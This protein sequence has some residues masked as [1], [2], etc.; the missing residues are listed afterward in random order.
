MKVDVTTATNSCQSVYPSRQGFGETRLALLLTCNVVVTLLNIIVNIFLIFA[1][2][3]T[4]QLRNLSCKLIACLSL[5]DICVGLVLQNV[6]SVLLTAF[7]SENGN[8][9]VE[10]V[11]QFLSYTFPQI[12]GVMIMIIALDR[13]VHMKFL[14][15]YS[16]MMNQRTACFMI[17]GNVVFALG[18]AIVSVVA[19]VYKKFFLF[20]AVL[21]I[22]DSIVI[23]LI[24]V[25]YIFT[26]RSVRAHMKGMR[27]RAKE[28]DRVEDYHRAQSTT[29]ALATTAAAAGAISKK[30][31]KR[32][33]QLAKTMV[34]ILTSL[35]VCYI[36][37][38]VVG[39]YW[40]YV[41][42]Y[43]NTMTSLALDTLVWVSFLL[44]YMNSSLNAIIFILRNK[45]MRRLLKGLLG[46]QS[47]TELSTIESSGPIQS[48]RV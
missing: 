26:F 5:S 1:L 33:A 40:S 17:L 24:Y 37:Y 6:V 7:K 16:S 46:F 35:T 13:W 21:I 38:F 2:K 15:K 18:I 28:N 32:D 12:S 30:V 29:P 3:A 9:T 42:Y 45:Q 8:C 10:L 41:R 39:L 34:L 36:P 23:L 11:S 14:N 22:M 4:N 19:S 31:D 20:N 25:A 48:S 27:R 44:V 43:K 47:P